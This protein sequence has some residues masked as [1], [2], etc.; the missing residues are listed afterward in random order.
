LSKASR[1]LDG[2]EAVQAIDELIWSLKI[3]GFDDFVARNTSVNF[4]L[5]NAIA[6][7]TGFQPN[8]TPDVI[9]EFIGIRNAARKAK[10]W[11]EADRIRDELA[12][13]GIALK[14]AKDPETGEI[15]TTWEIAR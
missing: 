11:A 5:D 10:N 14:D 3:I 1:S 2:E 12:A 13:Q 8:T 6:D 15:V 7:A 4:D 9:E